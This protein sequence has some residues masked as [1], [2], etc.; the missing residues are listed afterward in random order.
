VTVF[1][2]IY[3][4]FSFAVGSLHFSRVLWYIQKEDPIASFRRLRFFITVS[5]SFTTPGNYFAANSASNLPN[6]SASRRH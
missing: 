3:F 6:K 4:L 5:I 2:F 1:F